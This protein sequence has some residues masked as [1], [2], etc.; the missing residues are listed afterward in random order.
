MDLRNSWKFVLVIFWEEREN[1]KVKNE[2]M[3]PALIND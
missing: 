1:E 3:A 2:S